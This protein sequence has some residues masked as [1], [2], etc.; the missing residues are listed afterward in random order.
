LRQQLLRRLG[1]HVIFATAHA[2]QAK[3]AFQSI[4]S[5]TLIPG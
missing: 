4:E 5:L 3:I 1:P 2:G